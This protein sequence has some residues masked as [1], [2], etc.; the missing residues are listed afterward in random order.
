MLT[1]VG[2]FASTVCWPLSAFFVDELGWRGTCVAYASIHL[3]F[4][5]WVHVL[6]LPPVAGRPDNVP[7]PGNIQHPIATQRMLFGLMAGTITLSAAIS[8]VMSVHLLTILQAR[9]I[10]LAAAVAFGALVGPSQVGARF[11]EMVIARYH[12]PVWTKVASVAFVA[13][14]LGLLAAHIPLIALALIFYG[15]GIG[16]E[17]IARATLPLSL[18]GAE[19]YA[20]IMGKLAMPSLIA[21]AAAP[22]IGALL[23]EWFDADMT[24]AIIACAALANVLLALTLVIVTMGTVRQASSR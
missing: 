9:E 13:T 21:Q 19:R 8:T 23:L 16:L 15:A 14:G 1:L 2:G 3:L 5:F 17:S 7:T 24:L 18:F 20:P 11:L 10:A 6:A 4:T 12:H 22:S